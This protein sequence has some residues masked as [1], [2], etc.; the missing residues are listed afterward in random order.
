MQGRA[1]HTKAN[2][3]NLYRLY[4]RPLCLYAM[5]FLGDEMMAEDIVQ[6]CFIRFWEKSMTD[7]ISHPKPYLYMMVRNACLDAIRSM[8]DNKEALEATEK[9]SDE[10]LVEDSF[11]EARLWTAI[12]SLPDKCRNV[13]L[14]AKRDGK[15][16]DEISGELGISTN[17]VRNQ[18]SK[19][20][21]ILRD[22]A[23]K[24]IIHIF[25]FFA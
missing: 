16:Y 10:E 5:H 7:I 2:M 14:L 12:D 8:P 1:I 21:K 18:V 24:I 4:Y 23:E 13:F 22:G 9:L 3:E 11:I 20:L 17:T 19:A 25:S 15:S 6:D